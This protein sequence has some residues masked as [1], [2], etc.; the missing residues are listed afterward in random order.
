MSKSQ[1]NWLFV[2]LQ[3]LRGLPRIEAVPNANGVIFEKAFADFLG[4]L[5]T[6]RLFG[7]PMW[8]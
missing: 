7:R 6:P 2:F 5:A 1:K 8:W 3:E 4:H